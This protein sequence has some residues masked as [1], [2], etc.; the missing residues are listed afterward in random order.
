MLALRAWTMVRTGKSMVSDW[1]SGLCFVDVG[2][3]YA[4]IAQAF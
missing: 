2:R 1:G 4:N 3:W